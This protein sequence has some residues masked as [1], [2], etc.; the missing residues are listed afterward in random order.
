MA[1]RKFIKLKENGDFIYIE[2]WIDYD[3]TPTDDETLGTYSIPEDVPADAYC[4]EKQFISTVACMNRLIGPVEVRQAKLPTP[5]H[6]TRWIDTQKAGMWD[7]VKGEIDV[8]DNYAPSH[9]VSVVIR[10]RWVIC[11]LPHVVYERPYERCCY[12]PTNFRQQQL[13]DATESE[14][15]ALGEIINDQDLRLLEQMVSGRGPAHFV[16]ARVYKVPSHGPVMQ[17]VTYGFSVANH[18]YTEIL[19]E[20]GAE[21]AREIS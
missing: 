14:R 20:L 3:Y 4:I 17:E 19:K 16:A 21:G 7:L 5:E 6:A 12:I 13:R 9:D 11:D 15:K 1:D 10:G 8:Y 2:T 18:D